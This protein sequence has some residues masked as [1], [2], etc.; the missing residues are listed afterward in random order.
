MKGRT[1]GFMACAALLAGVSSCGALTLLVG[2]AGSTPAA[3]ACGP[4]AASG[5]PAVL[6][7]GAVPARVGAWSG[8]QITNAAQ[9]VKAGR[10]L[11]VPVRGQTIAVMTAMGE[12]SLRVLDRGD[13]A[14]P[15]SRG[16][17]Q[18]R[19]NG[20]WGSYED[21]MDPYRSSTNFYR[22]LLQ[23][24]GWQTMAP[25]LA[26]HATQHNADPWHYEPWWN[27]AVAVMTALTGISDLGAVL[28][29]GGDVPCAPATGLGGGGAGTD[30]QD[31]SVIPDPTTRRGCLTPRA[32]NVAQQ[33]AAQGWRLSCW[34]QHA[35][36]PTSDHP[37]G[38]ACD[39]FPGQ[40]GVLPSPSE[41]ARG[42]ALAADLRAHASD[43]GIHY[44]I[45][46]GRIWSVERSDEGW[47]PYNGAGIYNPSDVTGGH[48]DHLH[49]SVY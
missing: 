14:G 47:R 17:F 29:A 33:L 3:A 13:R 40:G 43:L 7:T 35:W 5:A 23:V 49:V 22:A 18:Q 21:R 12:S 1:L 30:P 42:D 11:N 15:D 4:P 44:V 48:Y 36:N 26:A 32:A 6:R 16:L 8:D 24:D 37:K 41:K 28:P 19:A 10:D 34:D 9:I 45:W 20:A 2:G 31:C 25:T 38:R 27:D 46:Y 39:V